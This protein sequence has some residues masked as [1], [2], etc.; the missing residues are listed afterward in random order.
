MGAP[1]G[2][3]SENFGPVFFWS[4]LES[5][6]S[7]GGGGMRVPVCM[8][9]VRCVDLLVCLALGHYVCWM[10]CCGKKDY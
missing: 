2:G 7:R 5:W 4:R 3:R 8:G 10:V 9:S 6:W 1:V